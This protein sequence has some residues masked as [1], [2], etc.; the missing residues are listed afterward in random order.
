M[1]LIAIC[2]LAAGCAAQPPMPPAVV[3]RPATQ[4]FLCVDV[5]V[6][7]APNSYI[8]QGPLDQARSPVMADL[9]DGVT[10]APGRCVTCAK[11]MMHVVCEGNL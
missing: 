6:L 10:L 9:P 7:F 2:L 11:Q 8:N 4:G 5:P 3:D 1:R